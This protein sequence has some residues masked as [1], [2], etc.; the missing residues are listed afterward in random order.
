MLRPAMH[1]PVPNR[2]QRVIAEMCLDPIQHARHQRLKPQRRVPVLIGQHMA[3]HIAGVEMWR[4]ADPLHLAMQRQPQRIA[5]GQFKQRH[6]Q[7]G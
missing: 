1:H 6:F 7:A 2:D 5:A 4:A 3:G